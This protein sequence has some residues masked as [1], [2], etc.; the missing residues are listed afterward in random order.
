[1]RSQ[2]QSVL[3]HRDHFTQSTARKWL[4]EHSYK[5]QTASQ[6]NLCDVKPND[7]YKYRYRQ[8]SP[9]KFS[10]YVT[11]S[12]EGGKIHLIVGFT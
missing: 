3:F 2:V 4:K 7:I 8:Q 5:Y 11:R 9:K 6:G 10:R 1:M 12:I